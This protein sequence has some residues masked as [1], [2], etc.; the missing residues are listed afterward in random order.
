MACG[1]ALLRAKLLAEMVIDCAAATELLHQ[2]GADPAR[3][4][5]AEA[6]IH[7][8]ALE[9]EHKARRI[10]EHGDGRVEL[11]AQVLAALHPQG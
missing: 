5:L 7:R 4:P 3:L 8:H 2:A 1:Y 9:C 6:F 10:Q 11:D